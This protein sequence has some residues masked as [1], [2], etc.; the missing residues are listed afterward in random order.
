MTFRVTHFDI[1]GQRHQLIVQACS[2]ALAMSWAEQL[3]GDAR[4]LSAIRL[5]KAGNV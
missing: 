3:Y 2:N 5:S 1:N 4:Y